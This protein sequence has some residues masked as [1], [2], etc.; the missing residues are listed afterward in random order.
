M[1]DAWVTA[2]TKI[3][4]FAEDRVSGWDV[5]VDTNN[6]VVT[7]TGKVD[8]AD[9]KNAADEVARTIEGVRDVKNDL[10]V[11]ERSQRGA[12]AFRG[13]RRQSR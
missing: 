7:L 8:S 10:Q 11:V 3:A 2:K 12:I 9:A 5:K 1:S 4:L 13:R 6:G